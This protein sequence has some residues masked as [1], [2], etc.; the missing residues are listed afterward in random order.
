M[1][2]FCFKIDLWIN[3][4]VQIRKTPFLFD[5]NDRISPEFF[6]S[7]VGTAFQLFH[8]NCNFWVDVSLDTGWQYERLVLVEHQLSVFLCLHLF[9]WGGSYW[10]PTSRLFLPTVFW[11]II[12]HKQYWGYIYSSCICNICYP[13]R[14]SPKGIC[15]LRSIP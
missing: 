2:V 13:L 1:Y 6:E 3:F 14:D 9:F 11:L 5:F 10:S 7:V 8:W 12:L 4:L 15:P